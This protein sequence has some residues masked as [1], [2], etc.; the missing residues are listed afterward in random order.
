MIMERVE[1][2]GVGGVVWCRKPA[3]NQDSWM[4]SL[5]SGEVYSHPTQE[6]ARQMILKHLREIG[7]IK[8]PENNS[9]LDKRDTAILQGCILN[10]S[11]REGP[12]VG[13]F[14]ELSDAQLL[15]FT[16]NW[17]DGIQTTWKGHGEG[18]FYLGNNGVASYSGSLD[19]IIPFEK[20]KDTLSTR[21]GRFW[22]FSHGEARAHNGVDVW[23]PCR[24]YKYED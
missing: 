19:P 3:P 6:G 7:V 14:L 5:P 8:V 24:V 22:F 10:W 15:R 23:V 20:I 12:R 2:N 1:V 18:S 16:H 21:N 17:G 11:K 13:D 4:Y 9:H